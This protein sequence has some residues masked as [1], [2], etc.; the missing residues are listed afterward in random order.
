MIFV[1]DKLSDSV[2]YNP[3]R[4]HYFKYAANVTEQT[5]NSWVTTHGGILSDLIHSGME[6]NAALL[7]DITTETNLVYLV[8]PWPA[9][10]G[11]I[12]QQPGIS[13]PNHWHLALQHIH[14]IALTLAKEGRLTIVFHIPEFLTGP[15]NTN[16]NIN[17][18]IKQVGIP[19]AQI[20]FV[21]GLKTPGWYYWPGFEY[22]HLTDIEEIRQITEVNLK[23]RSK[24]FTCLNRVDKVHRRYMALN[25]WKHNLLDDGYVSYSAGVYTDTGVQT[26]STGKAV[27]YLDE[28]QDELKDWN[29]FSVGIPY[30]ADTLTLE[31]HNDHSHCEAPHY[32]DAYWN[33]A[34]ETGIENDTFLSEKTFKPISKL[35]P[36]VV[37]GSYKS[38]ALLHDLGY[39]T[40]DCVIDE[41]YDLIS[42]DK[43]RIKAASDIAIQIASWTHEKHIEVMK[44]IKPILEHNQKHF[45]AKKHRIN[46]FTGYLLNNNPDYN[47]LSDCTYD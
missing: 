22:S 44:Q 15:H 6:F 16:K 25:L 33:F 30:K 11:L 17:N 32:T 18:I 24:K 19:S 21:S 38:L 5:A 27:M 36:F 10:S 31:Q 26:D 8:E 39:K 3:E 42:D 14:P 23:Q 20:K 34:T 9:F 1:F 45:F 37:L 13:C 7:S 40:F 47:W 46:T 2:Y 12:E 4:R 29:K 41:S 28:W 35:Q 43:E